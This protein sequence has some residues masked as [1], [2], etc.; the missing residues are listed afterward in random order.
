MNTDSYLTPVEAARIAGPLI[1]PAGPASP[2]VMRAR[3]VRAL[4]LM[5]ELLGYADS[6]VIGE[7]DDAAHGVVLAQVSDR[8]RALAGAEPHRVARLLAGV[9]EGRV[10]EALNALLAYRTPAETNADYR[11]A[12]QDG[13]VDYDN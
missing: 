7:G 11:A 12:G 8:F 4:R 13:S 3:K 6:L 2:N 5:T 9:E 10:E 1:G